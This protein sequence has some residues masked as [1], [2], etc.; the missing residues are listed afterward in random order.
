MWQYI[1]LALTLPWSFGTCGIR[2]VRRILA[3][4]GPQGC[5]HGIKVGLLLKLANVLLVANS[6][7]AKPVGDLAEKNQ[8][9]EHKIR[10]T[11]FH[12]KEHTSVTDK[13]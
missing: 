8:D 10:Y 13:P 7:V 5:L 6:L 3:L 4:S 9:K 11:R 12:L 1:S 2:S